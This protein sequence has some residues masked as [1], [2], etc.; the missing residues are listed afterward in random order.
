VA[1]ILFATKRARPDTGTSIS[2]LM[3]RVREPDQ[4]DWSKLSNLMKY[5]RAPKDLPL[6]LSADGTGILKW[7][8]DGSYTVHPNMRVLEYW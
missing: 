2:F 3:T 4:D 1:K 5:I 8:V 7:Y 6:I